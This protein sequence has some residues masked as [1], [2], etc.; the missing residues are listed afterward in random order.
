M[1]YLASRRQAYDHP[2]HVMEGARCVVMLTLD[3]RTDEPREPAAGEGRISRYAWGGAD[4][5]DVIHERLKRLISEAKAKAPEWSWR[6]V[7]DTAPL[8]EREFAHLAGLGWQGKHTLLLNRTGG[9]WFFLA[10][11]VTDAP[12]EINLTPP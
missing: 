5:H 4:Y 6:G 9:S 11:L 7:V 1:Q 8:M 3:Y 2:R 10:A 12:L